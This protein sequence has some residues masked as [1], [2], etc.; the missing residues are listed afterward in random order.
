MG[1]SRKTTL[2][3][4]NSMKGMSMNNRSEK[5]ACISLQVDKDMKSNMTRQIVSGHLGEI[6]LIYSA[7]PCSDPAD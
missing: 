7:F 4:D 3:E 1:R 6:G 2:R 5:A